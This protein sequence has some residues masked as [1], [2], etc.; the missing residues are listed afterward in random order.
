MDEGTDA[1]SRLSWKPRA[2]W[3]NTQGR[4]SA[5]RVWGDA[6]PVFDLVRDAIADLEPRSTRVEHRR[7]H[8]EELFERREEIEPLEAGTMS[9]PTTASVIHDI[10]YKPYTGPRLGRRRI[11]RGPST[12]TACAPASGWA[13]GPKAKIVPWSSCLLVMLI[14]A[15]LVNYVYMVSMGATGPVMSGTSA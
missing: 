1:L 8:V 10:G 14:P 3:C 15:A 4:A 13:A 6:D 7:H 11:P 5:G 12:S 9:T 2:W